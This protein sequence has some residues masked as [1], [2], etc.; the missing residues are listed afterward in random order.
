MANRNRTQGNNFERIICKE[1]KELGFEAVTSRSESRNLDNL[2]V[3]IVTNLPYHIQCK[4]MVKQPKYHTLLTTMP[5]DKEPV[6][7]HRQTHKAKSR[8]VTDGDYVIMKKEL[9]YKLIKENEHN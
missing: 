3:D 9:F 2:G 6:V 4:N 1:L 7:I 8:F 5:T